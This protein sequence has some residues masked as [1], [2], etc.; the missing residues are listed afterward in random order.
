[1]L[2]HKTRS[3]NL[4]HKVPPLNTAEGAR[5]TQAK[6]SACVGLSL[7]S[8]SQDW[9]PLIPALRCPAPCTGA[10]GVRTPTAPKQMICGCPHYAWFLQLLSA[11]E[12]RKPWGL[13]RCMHVEATA[14]RTMVQRASASSCTLARQLHWCRCVSGPPGCSASNA[15]HRAN[16]PH[17][18]VHCHFYFPWPAWSAR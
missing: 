9:T 15:L 14:H 11:F 2:P 17:D 13:L 16:V 5:D 6:P 3:S 1:M 18:Q 4:G 7:V 10:L 8:C 12:H